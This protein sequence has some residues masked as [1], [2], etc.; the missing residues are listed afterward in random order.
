MDNKNSH[1]LPEGYIP[2]EYIEYRPKREQLHA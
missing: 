2:L 1:K